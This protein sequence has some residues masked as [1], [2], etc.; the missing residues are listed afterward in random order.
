MILVDVRRRLS[1]GGVAGRP[2]NRVSEVNRPT[3][4]EAL[5]AVQ[6]LARHGVPPGTDGR[7]ARRRLNHLS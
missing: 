4:E 5:K 1:Y 6:Q 7:K 2:R 3:D